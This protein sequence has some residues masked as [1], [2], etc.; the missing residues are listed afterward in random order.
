MATTTSTDD[1]P[2][3]EALPGEQLNVDKMPG[4]WLLARMGKRVLRP[5][6]VELTQ[7]MLS[8]LAI[9]GDDIVV[10]LA[11][12]LGAT[13]RL[14]LAMRPKKYIGIERD[15]KA[16]AHVRKLIDTSRD[17]II[18]GNAS[19]SGLTDQSCDVVYGE[20]MLTM[21]LPSQRAKIVGEAF[22]VLR[23]GGQYAIHE[24]GLKP[25]DLDESTKSKILN[26]V[27]AAIKVGA[28][29]L[30]VS[31]WCRVLE[32]EGFAVAPG[33]IVTAPMHLLE[34]RR[35]F[36][37]EGFFR[38]LRIATNVLRT[39]AARNRILAMRRVFRRYGDHLCA[40]SMIGRKPTST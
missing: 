7:Q 13:A 30:T 23:P 39:P 3:G 29:P 26:E 21:Q 1:L 25:D 40:I 10:E 16:A 2:D 33:S 27:S 24:L 31:E 4:H 28:R 17:E 11:P 22:R 35:V 5:G 9:A 14:T 19:D 37:D 8:G 38:T 18:G 6:G 32:G 15:P 20:A 12:G 34:P 36:R